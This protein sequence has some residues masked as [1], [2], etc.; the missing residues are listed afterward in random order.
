MEGVTS[1]CFYCTY[2]EYKE[3]P[4]FVLFSQCDSFY[5]TYME[6]KV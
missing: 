6:Y 4:V 1:L 2:M 5:C 3:P